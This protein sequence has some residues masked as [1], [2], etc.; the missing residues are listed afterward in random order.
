ML[1]WPLRVVKFLRP[2]IVKVSERIRNMFVERPILHGYPRELDANTRRRHNCVFLFTESFSY[3]QE[4]TTKVFICTEDCWKH[5][6]QKK[7]Y[8]KNKTKRKPMVKLWVVFQSHL[9]LPYLLHPCLDDH[10]QRN[11]VHEMAKQ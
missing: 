11:V 5:F 8:S 9:R 7:L 1:F 6:H 4:K 10:P 3:H 2:V